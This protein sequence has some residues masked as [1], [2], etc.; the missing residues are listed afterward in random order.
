MGR[1][2]HRWRATEDG[3]F[4]IRT[5]RIPVSLQC[6]VHG[7]ELFNVVFYLIICFRF[8]STLFLIQRSFSSKLMLKLLVAFD[9][10]LSGMA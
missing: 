9:G 5:L 3:Y 7:T 1:S 4:S 6:K 8:M 2:G 10:F